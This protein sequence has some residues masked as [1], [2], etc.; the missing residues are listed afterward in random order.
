M[1]E[2][3]TELFDARPLE[4]PPAHRLT[5]APRYGK[6][7]VGTCSCGRI[8]EGKDSDAVADAFKR[9]HAGPCR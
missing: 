8:F 9:H 1:P 3:Q 4:Q 2:T 6:N 7:V 5:F